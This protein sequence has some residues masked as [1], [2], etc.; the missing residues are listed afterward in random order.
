MASLS[1]KKPIPAQIVNEGATFG[2]LNLHDF[3]Q[4][5]NKMTIRAELVD[6][7]PL[8]KGL[9]CTTD[10]IING[11]PAADT[12]GSYKV[13]IFVTNE[14]TEELTTEFDFT[15]NPRLSM[16]DEKNQIYSKLKAEVWE[17]LGKNLPLP[18]LAELLNRPITLTEIYY[19]LQRFATL[20]IWDVYNL[21]YPGE[22]NLL[23]LEGVSKHYHVY[24]RGCCI[25]GAPKE[26]FS[27]ERTLADAMNT[28][29]AM[30]REVYKR[31]W[32]IEFAGFD[33]MVRSAW[34]ELQLLSEQHG[35]PLEILHY[36]PSMADVKIFDAEL[37][38]K[39]STGLTPG[40]EI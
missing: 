6:G 38:G 18:D 11:I 39:Q 9:I 20:T 5:E 4:S 12:Q 1:L 30:A 35:K 22:K 31:G 37:K 33:K 15:I 27:H 13:M 3:I 19:L 10:G 7:Q 23:N 8:P 16:G 40:Q 26:L 14:E 32:V 21:D 24:D 28:A 17:A 2:P 29:R 34:V 25:V 36:N